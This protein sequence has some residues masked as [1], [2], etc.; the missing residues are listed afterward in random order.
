MNDQVKVAFASGTDELNRALIAEMRGIFQELPLFVVSDFPPEDRDV[1]WLPYHV[2]RTLWENLALCRAGL[3]GMR[4]R[5]AGVMLVPGVPFRRMRLMALLLSPRGFIAFNENLNHFMLRPASAAAILRH[6]VWRAANIFRASIRGGE[7]SVDTDGPPVAK[8]PVAVFAGRTATGKPRVMVASCYM[9]FP[10]SHGGAV[11]MYNL[12]RRA[13]EDF[14][15]TLV[16]FV[17]ELS[18]PPAEVLEICTEVVMVRREGT[19]SLPSRGSPDVV[20]EFCSQ[21]FQA[22]LRAAVARWRPG[23]VQLEFTQMA[24]YA[25]DCGPARTVLVEHDITFDLYDQIYRSS[26]DWEVGYQLKRWR[27]FEHE[28]WKRVDRIVVMSERDRLLVGG[29]AR[30]LPNGVDLER[31]RPAPV[32]P[33]IRRILFIGSFA[34]LP[35]LLALEFFLNEVWE[36]IKEAKLHVIAGSRHEYF[37]EYYR[38]RVRLELD[39][40]GIEVEGFVADVRPAYERAMVVVAPLVASAGTNIKVLEAMAMGRAVV[41][42]VAGI[43]GLDLSPGTDVIVAGNAA[44]M[45]EAIGF[46]F[47]DTP[48]RARIEAAARATVQREFG[49]DAIARKQAALYGEMIACAS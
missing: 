14:D 19:H 46:L 36:G 7:M 49:W 33:E 24:Q 45:A 20:E 22:A 15:Q 44:A 3:R 48:A 2:N 26:G 25:R 16:V 42:T 12:M 38:D 21:A 41:S 10:L 47:A 35:N 29:R 11:R 34:H 43:N 8:D 5:L 37:L 40:P 31:F 23:I 18:M 13:A 27:R 9:I 17:D 6:L 28:A 39:R 32:Q 4:I 1:K 30:T